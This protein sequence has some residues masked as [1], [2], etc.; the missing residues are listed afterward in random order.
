MFSHTSKVAVQRP[1]V[2]TG[3]KVSVNE[4]EARA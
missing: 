1:A 4:V 2:I 3:R